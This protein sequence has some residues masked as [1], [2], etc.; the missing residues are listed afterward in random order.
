[1][2]DSMFEVGFS[3]NDFYYVNAGYAKPDAPWKP[4][5]TSCNASDIKALIGNTEAC[6][7][8]FSSNSDNCIKKAVCKNKEL[9]DEIE[10]IVNSHLGS[11]GGYEDSQTLYKEQYKKIINNSVSIAFIVFLIFYTNK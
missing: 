2:S 4:D 1:M 9:A 11:N 6:G 3:K 7:T 5:V 10:S 8:S